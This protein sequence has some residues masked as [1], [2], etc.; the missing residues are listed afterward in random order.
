MLI[1]AKKPEGSAPLFSEPLQPVEVKEGS[2]AKL[3]CTV[4]AEPKPNIEWFKKGV[5]VKENRRV[6][7]ES[8]GHTV[9]LT[10]K[11]V[12]SFDE[13]EYKCVATN[14]LGSAPCNASLTVRAIAKPD[15][16]D[17]LKT[18]E[19]ME[20]DT[21]QF[22]TRVV[23]YPAPEVEWFK[24]ATKLKSDER[25]EIKENQDDNLYSLVINDAKRDDAGIYKCVAA[26]EGGKR[27]DIPNDKFQG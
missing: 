6:K 3:Q 20:G 8:D 24:G 7:L 16:K 25:T 26:N 10:I 21:V 27:R 2:D 4:T 23:G 13:G 22:D 12:R 14:E 15:F 19:V 9:S 5:R 17:K 1:A 18:V 11:Q